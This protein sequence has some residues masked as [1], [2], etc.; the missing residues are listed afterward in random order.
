MKRR[1][2]LIAALLTAVLLQPATVAQAQNCALMPS[3]G[4]AA[5]MEHLFGG[6]PSSGSVLVR[7][8]YVTQYDPVHRMPRWSA[9]EAEPDNLHPPARAGQWATFRT[10]PDVTSPVR[11]QDYTGVGAAQMARGHIVP[12]FMSGGDRDHDGSRAPNDPYDN[13]TIYEVNYM[14]NVAPQLN[15]LNGTSGTWNKLETRVRDDLVGGGLTIHIIAGPVFGDAPVQYIGNGGI[16]IPHMFF[17]ILVTPY[18]VV[19]FLFVHTAQLGSSGCELDA[20]LEACIVAISDIEALTGL[21]FF[22]VFSPEF[23]AVL[24]TPDGGAV[25]QVLVGS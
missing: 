22:T 5:Q 1:L 24:K 10:D 4:A 7:R 12:Y 8:A 13:C 11:T 18:G 16:P 15:A 19:P 25:W 21:D 17:Q 20:V 2:A 3:Q 23:Q 6:Q 14:T 9:W